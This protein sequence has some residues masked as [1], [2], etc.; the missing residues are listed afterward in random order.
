M[1]GERHGCLGLRPSPPG[2]DALE[3][4]ATL[5]DAA[6]QERPAAGH[7]RPRYHTSWDCWGWNGVPSLSPLLET[8]H[9]AQCLGGVVASM[10]LGAQ[11]GEV[12]CAIGRVSLW[13]GVM[14]K[15]RVL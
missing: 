6:D 10:D 5:P 4:D 14:S 13:R 2:R 9:S 8:L 1:V 12:D 3:L 7:M 11:A 15:T